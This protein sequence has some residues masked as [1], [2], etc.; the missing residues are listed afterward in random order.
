MLIQ[1]LKEYG[2]PA[3]PAVI[4]LALV[5]AALWLWRSSGS[6]AARVYVALLAAGYWLMATPVGATLMVSPLAPALARVDSRDDAMGADTIVLLGGGAATATVAGHTVAVPTATTLLRSLE[7]ARV[8]RVA[9]GRLLIA[10]GGRP[11]PERQLIAESALM[12]KIVVEAGVPEDRVVEESRSTTT[13]EQA[14]LVRDA[15]RARGVGRVILVASPTQMRRALALFRAA[16]VE[17]VGSMS[18]FRSDGVPPPP[19]LLPNSDSLA[20]SDDAV[21]EYAALMYYWARG[22]IALR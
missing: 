9:Q 16:G 22:R 13:A 18:P 5:V 12:R 4:V 19:L 14:V 8:F 3:S 6:I 2:H 17:A 20:M 11:R 15:L 7:A 1:A 21:Y 10:S